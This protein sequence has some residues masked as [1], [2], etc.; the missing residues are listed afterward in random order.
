[1]E[2]KECLVSSQSLNYLSLGPLAA[3]LEGGHG[4]ENSVTVGEDEK[5]VVLAS[6]ALM[7][8]LPK[9]GTG[10]YSQ[11]PETREHG[12]TRWVVTQKRIRDGERG[13]S[14]CSQQVLTRHQTKK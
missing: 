8:R 5:T 10:G 9:G 6:Q 11:G 7:T 12:D 1:M 4:E 3:E 13:V 14:F 2:G